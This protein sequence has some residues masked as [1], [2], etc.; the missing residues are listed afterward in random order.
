MPVKRPT[1]SGVE[2][3]VARPLP[4]GAFSVTVGENIWALQGIAQS[5][6]RWTYHYQNTEGLLKDGWIID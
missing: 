1:D 4:K 6:R 3:A 2:V 5:G